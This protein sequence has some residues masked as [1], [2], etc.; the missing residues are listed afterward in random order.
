[1]RRDQVVPI[2]ELNLEDLIAIA[3]S[4]LTRGLTEEECQKYLHME[5]CPI[6][7]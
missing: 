3:Q 6:E 5:Q 4:R 2:Y 7:P 1:V